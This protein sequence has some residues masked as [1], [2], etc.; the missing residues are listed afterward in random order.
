MTTTLI[1]TPTAGSR[2]QFVNWADLTNWSVRFAL[3]NRFQYNPAYQLRA[4]GSF[5]RRVKTEVVIQ[6]QTTYQRVTVRVNNRGVV[7][8]DT[9]LGRNIGTK[10]QFQV[11]TGQ[12][13]V[14][15]IDA[16][17]GAM[18]LVP[19]QLAG[20]VVTAD[21]LPFEVDTEQ[22][23]PRF[24][25]LITSTREFIQFCQSCSSGTTNR[26]RLDEQLFLA[27]KIPLPSLDE[28][29]Q[30]VAAY[31]AKTQ[32]AQQMRQEAEKGI[33][34][35]EAYLMR[36]LGIHIEASTRTTGKLNFVNFSDLER[37]DTAYALRAV[38][39]K[40]AYPQAPISDFIAHFMRDADGGTVRIN[41][42]DFATQSF[43]YVGMEHVEKNTGRLVDAKAI[44]G[45]ELKSQTLRVPP[46]FF[47]YGKLR[48]YLNKY[49]R[50]DAG[51][52]NVVCSSEFFAF[53]LNDEINA[54]YFLTVLRSEIIQQQI[55]DNTSGARMPRMNESTFLNLKIPVPNSD[56]QLA[57]VRVYEEA[58]RKRD[59]L[60]VYANLLDTSAVAK[61]EEDVFE[62]SSLH[63]KV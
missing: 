26:Q 58:A 5:L 49:W 59:E 46:G 56:K 28:Q 51:Q 22:I 12:F 21:F 6:D 47:I 61:F 27:M 55:Q 16:R 18:G 31:Y 34:D 9:E 1:P 60:Q 41:T 43:F 35:A 11:A 29:R 62:V 20:A 13:L 48:P 23:D 24:L 32:Q 7:P 19:D 42:M 54:D 2:F 33:K 17:H 40:A 52:E 10:R 44:K 53:A 38:K 36:E 15:R 50:N 45:K 3:E 39:M 25:V 63:H 57:I 4:L 37:W 8:R 30:L 14:S